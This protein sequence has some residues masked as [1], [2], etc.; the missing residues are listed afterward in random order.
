MTTTTLTKL[1]SQLADHSSPRTEAMIQADVRQFL[2]SAP[3]D[4]EDQDLNDILLESP[5]GD[6]RRIDIELGAT[7]IEVK[8]DL[9]KGKVREDA[10]DQLFGYVE[11]RIQ[12]TSQRYVGLLTDGA[13]W[14]CYHT[15]ANKLELVTSITVSP[16]S[17]NLDAFLVWLDGVLAT[18]KA[19]VPTAET[20][21]ARLGAQS[22]SHSLDKSSL[23]ALY[24]ENKDRPS[25]ALKRKL[26]A[27]LLTSALG[28]QFQDSDDLFVEHTYLVNAAEIIAHALL[29][30]PVTTLSPAALLSGS[31]FDESGIRGVVER[32]FFDWVI[33]VKS[34]DSFIRSVA[35]RLARF[36][37][38]KVE[39]DVLK[40]LY[41]SV[42]GQ[43]T[44][45]RL[46]EYY[47]PDWLAFRMVQDTIKNP[48]SAR[49]L[50]P[51]CGSG[52]FLFHA[53]RLYIE[54]AEQNKIPLPKILDSV[55][56]HVIGLDLHPVAVTL[57]RVTYLLAIGRSRLVDPQRGPIQ[58]P[59]FL[60]DSIQWR[61]QQTDLWGS[62]S[63]TIHADDNRELFSTELRFPDALLED[64]GGFDWLVQ[65]LADKAS[66]RKTG[67]AI[68][69][70]SGV[71]QRLGIPSKF[72]EIIGDTFKIMCGL[73]DQGRDHIWG[74][75]V[76]NLARPM[77]LARPQNRVDVLIGNP[78]WLAFRHMTPEMQELFRRMSKSRNLWQGPTVATHQDLS[79]LFVVRAV[80]LYLK[81][82]GRFALVM[83]NAAVDREQYSGFRTGHYPD[84][85]EPLDVRFGI[86]WD[87]RRLRPHFFP[88][89]SSVVFGERQKHAAQMPREVE[90]WT[91]RL[92]SL[93]ASW[94]N[95]EKQLDRK[96]GLAQIVDGEEQS[97][98][99]TRFTQGATFSPRV[100]FM[101][102]Q[103]SSGP[104]G[105]PVGRIAIVS[106]RN[107]NEKKPWS[108][109]EDVEGIVET[110]F[111]R[112]LYN[113]ENLLPF[114]MTEPDKV[115]VPWDSTELMT[116]SSDR[117]ELYPGLADWWRRAERIWDENRSSERLTLLERL[118]YRNELAKQFPTPALRIVY[119]K[120][121]M[122]LAAALIT[123]DHAVINSGLYWATA[124]SADEG[125]YL[126]AILN[127]PITTELVRPYMSYGKD[128]RDIHKH[129]WELPIE[130]Y[131]TENDMHMRLAGL[132]KQATTLASRLELR[133]ELHFASQRRQIR[134][135]IADT[136]VGKRINEIAFEC[137]S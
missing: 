35:K 63:L 57:A 108:K 82:G 38:S 23:Q 77:W 120:S 18:E 76:R 123:D 117:I 106:S 128:E 49:V 99:R 98:Y 59:V 53:V 33:E 32:D 62:G 132:G 71:F 45:K 66:V 116:G 22:S 95:V 75:Y 52:T 47:T 83:P 8:K 131:D 56:K 84:S 12:Q 72:H 13:T 113:G 121:G 48:L 65:E 6:R 60:G 85:I 34:G 37:W 130:E 127:S 31:K 79:A 104:L 97:P 19:I 125:Y 51:A 30:L 20:I 67:T 114:R 133:K 107:A 41:E 14:E 105:T 119:N 111:V 10:V 44:R 110:E 9:K 11:T 102:E 103:R 27:R 46:G 69:S 96:T 36:D 16:A 5:L 28:T 118:N 115:V 24:C 21:K 39:Q 55:T 25:V 136:E 3:L 2:L 93:N 43:E 135:Y 91:G 40:V 1:L 109:L 54:A 29:G 80:Q 126:C 4:L 87:L 129:V 81:E 17:P 15:R 61:E 7:V 124:A 134:E 64:A 42:I 70:L 58:V 50:D 86:S 112:P 137:L 26:W 89:G 88:R 100:L 74:Y 92:P 101:V 90:V 122:H 73:H 94:T 78:P 68:P